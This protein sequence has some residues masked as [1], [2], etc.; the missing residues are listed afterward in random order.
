MIYKDDIRIGVVSTI[1]LMD[2]NFSIE[3]IWSTND[4]GRSPPPF[5]QNN[6]T[7]FSYCDLILPPFPR[8]LKPTTFMPAF[9]NL[10][11]KCP[12]RDDIYQT[13]LIYSENAKIE[14]FYLEI[15]YGYPIKEIDGVG[16]LSLTD[17][18]I[19]VEIPFINPGMR[20]SQKNT[21][22]TTVVLDKDYNINMTKIITNV[23][24]KYYTKGTFNSY[25]NY[26]DNDNFCHSGR[27]VF[28][29]SGS[30]EKFIDI[31]NNRVLIEV[32]N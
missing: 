2:E 3:G 15:T 17:N 26:I 1:N 10:S 28:G 22:V 27:F 18:S 11:D 16:S 31:L 32:F 4:G 6:V 12:Y 24:A 21:Q 14:D 29:D 7:G 25:W 8:K 5:Y 19:I 13:I 9:V 23:E 30:K 20:F